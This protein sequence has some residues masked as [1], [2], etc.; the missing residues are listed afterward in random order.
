M[1]EVIAE[2]A[3]LMHTRLGIGGDSL[4]DRLRRAGRR[5]PQRLRAQARALAR[6]E[7]LANH[8]GLCRT[9][10]APA[11]C[12]AAAELRA[13]LRSID[14]ADRRRGWWLGMLSGLVFNLLV[15]AA[16]MLAVLRWRGYL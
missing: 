2:I 3:A 6:A 8:P 14:P 9:L 13:W 1:P 16:L 10:D 4:A 5:V 12:A 15:L 7:P 11:L